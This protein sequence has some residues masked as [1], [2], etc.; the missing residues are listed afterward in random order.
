MVSDCYQAAAAQ[1][2][3]QKT[4]ELRGECPESIGDGK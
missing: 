2:D 4:T 3:T 1:R